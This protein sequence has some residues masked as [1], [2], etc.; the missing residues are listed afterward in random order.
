MIG[1]EFSMLFGKGEFIIVL[2]VIKSFLKKVKHL[3]KKYM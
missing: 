2:Y 3:L 1:V